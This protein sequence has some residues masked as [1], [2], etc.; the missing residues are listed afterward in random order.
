MYSANV[1][2]NFNR[3]ANPQGTVRSSVSMN[4]G[5][6][7]KLLQKKMVITFNT[8]DPFMQQQNRQFTFGERFNQETYS[9]TQTRNFRLTVAYNFSKT[10]NKGRQQLLNQKKAI[11]AKPSGKRG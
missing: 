2:I 8:I 5:L 11:P 9:F 6:Q 7:A 1:G 10:V 4:I 3:F